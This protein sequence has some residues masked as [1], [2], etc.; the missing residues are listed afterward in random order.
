[1]DFIQGARGVAAMLV[2]LWHASRYLGPYGSGVGGALFHPAV[3]MGVDL[4][5]VLSGFIMV[6]TTRDNDGSLGY[7]WLFLI[8]RFTRVWP[9]YAVTLLA[10]VALLQPWEA[11]IW[12]KVTRA[13]VFMPL[14]SEG[15]SNVAPLFGVPPL[16]VGWTLAYEMYFYLAFGLS[17]L[18]GRLQWPMLIV[19]GFATLVAIPYTM[20]EQF[21]IQYAL[22][23]EYRPPYRSY[24]DL[25]TSPIIYMFLAGALIGALYL[26]PLRVRDA[27]QARF[28]LLSSATLII[29]Q[30]SS[31]TFLWHG[32]L[33][34]GVSIVPAMAGLCIASKTLSIP[35]PAWLVGLGGVS[36]SLYLWH[37]LVQMGFDRAAGA[38][39]RS[40]L[41][42]GTSPFITTTLLSVAVALVSQRHL[43]QNLSNALRRALTHWHNATRA[44]SP[45]AR[46]L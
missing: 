26:S 14:G 36:Y 3:T 24:L 32:L 10:T 34:A 28:L 38:F 11:G 37:P 25:L 1:M 2:L 6:V 13:L 40:D 31:H 20:S 46:G 16:S 15:D 33:G 7:A 27:F 12:S 44:K 22:I 9:T 45:N 29:W 41:A 19:W 18:A 5:F 43:E 35:C 39:G 4:F 8:K 17:L 42:V 30:Y 23:P 21:T